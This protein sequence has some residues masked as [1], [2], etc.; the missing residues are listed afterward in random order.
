[1]PHNVMS[2]AR[3]VLGVSFFSS[4]LL[5][6]CAAAFWK[7]CDRNCI[8]G[9]TGSSPMQLSRQCKELNATRQ[10]TLRGTLARQTRRLLNQKI[11]IQVHPS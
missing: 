3:G 7:P 2:G 10:E 1:M 9:A 6:F 11:Q 8:I 5:C 4:P